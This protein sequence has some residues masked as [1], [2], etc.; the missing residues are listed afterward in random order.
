MFMKKIAKFAALSAAAALILTAC[1][2]SGGMEKDEYADKIEAAGN[3]VY[4]HYD[5]S[6]S[7]PELIDGKNATVVA[8]MTVKSRGDSYR[9]A[10]EY[11]IKLGDVYFGDVKTGDEVTLVTDY[12]VYDGETYRTAGSTVFRVGGE[13]MVLL[14]SAPMSDLIPESGKD[15]EVYFVCPSDT[16]AVKISGEY[17]P[18]GVF[19]SFGSVSELKKGV[20]ELCKG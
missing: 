6:D 8:T 11:T 16:G 4:P 2:A 14:K 13:Y 15:G 18:A 5:F 10:T 19:E 7:I 20:A 9:M 12:S 3:N 17:T 1:G